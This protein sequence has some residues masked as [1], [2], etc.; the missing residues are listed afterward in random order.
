MYGKLH[1]KFSHLKFHF[2]N[3]LRW[4]NDQKNYRPQKSMQ[5]YS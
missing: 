2:L 4:K 1:L 3:D 5:L